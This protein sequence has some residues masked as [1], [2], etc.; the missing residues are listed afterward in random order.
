MFSRMYVIVSFGYIASKIILHFFKVMLYIIK[1]FG[2][3]W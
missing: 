3:I 1:L 2:N